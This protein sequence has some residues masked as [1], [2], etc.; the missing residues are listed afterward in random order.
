MYSELNFL[1]ESWLQVFTN[2]QPEAVISQSQHKELTDYQRLMESC[3]HE[4]HRV[5]KPG[6]WMTVEFHN[7]QNRVWN[8]IQEAILRAGFMVADV[9]TFD[10]QQGSFNQVTASG[11]VKQDLII[12][13]YKPNGGLEQRF[14]LEAGTEAG[15]W[16]FVRAHLR[17]LPVWVA[18]E[19]QVEVIHERMNYMLFDRM[20][21]FHVQ[22]GATVPLSAAE[23]YAGLP[24][25][26]PE[27]DQMYFSPD[28]V[29]EYD[30]R[31]ATAREVLQLPLLVTDEASA[32]QWL[33]QALVQRPQ[34]FQE[35]HPQ[36]IRELGGWQ[37]HETLLELSSLLEQSFLRYDG[38][39]PI[40]EQ[41]WTW[42]R[43]DADLRE[44]TKGQTRESASLTL[45]LRAK[46]RWYVP[47]SNRT[48]DL[49]KLR[50]RTLLKE[51]DAYR[52]SPERRLKVFRLEAVRA[53]FR[54]AWQERDYRTIIEIAAKI[55]EAVLQED[56][57]L[58]MWYDQ[59]VTRTEPTQFT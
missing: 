10:K 47:D 13:A 1:W 16:D 11:S 20:V 27:R 26:F 21:A 15:A 43:L 50:E 59:A 49:E 25:R 30:T 34:T 38:Q 42:M 44:L 9:R 29:V 12:S 14:G 52:A 31:R 17:Q 2:S 58:L 40:P 41:I 8:A 53:G 46:D 6:H 19:G 24:Q 18:R 45:R 56:P 55:P 4:F 5:L 51:F 39:G 37:K 57:K 33:R 23:F 7:S 22:R 35:I 48:G 32:I 28:Q 3:F 54:R 36:F